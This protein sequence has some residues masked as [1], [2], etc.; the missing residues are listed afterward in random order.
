M[1]SQHTRSVI[2]QA[3]CI[4][5]SQKANWE[6]THSGQFV[7]IEPAAQN[8][9]F[10]DTF[11]AAVRAASEKYPDRLSYTLRIGH[12]A[13]FHIGLISLNYSCGFTFSAAEPAA[14]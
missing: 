8:W 14:F 12:E 1:I 11:D 6:Q 10:A 2:E 13:V 3:R 5:A 4:F 7:A 9:F